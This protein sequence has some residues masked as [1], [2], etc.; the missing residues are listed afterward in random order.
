MR[1]L[2]Y[3]LA[4]ALAVKIRLFAIYRSVNRREYE[5]YNDREL[6]RGFLEQTM[7]GHTRISAPSSFE[8]DHP[9]PNPLWRFVKRAGVD[10]GSS[11]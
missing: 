1:H 7:E 3:A 11:R 6:A 5:D 9:G 8:L 4:L 10:P 2:A